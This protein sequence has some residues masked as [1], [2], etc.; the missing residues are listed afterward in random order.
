MNMVVT[1]LRI[2]DYRYRKHKALAV[3]DDLSFNEY[4][5]LMLEE[6]MLEMQFSRKKGQRVKKNDFYDAMDA[7]INDS[8]PNEPMGASAEDEIIYD[9]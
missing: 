2:P 5:N 4:V 7:L 3:E 1:N 6:K 8:H 9:G